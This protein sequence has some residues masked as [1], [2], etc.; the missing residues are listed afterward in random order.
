MFGGLSLLHLPDTRMCKFGW[1]TVPCRRSCHGMRDCS[2]VCLCHR[3]ALQT[4]YA[5]GFG[6]HIGRIPVS[7]KLQSSGRN[8]GDYVPGLVNLDG[9]ADCVGAT[10]KHVKVNGVA[11]LQSLMDRDICGRQPPSAARIGPFILGRSGWQF[12]RLWRFWTCELLASCHIISGCHVASMADL[13]K[14]YV[15]CWTWLAQHNLQLICAC[16]KGRPVDLSLEVAPAA[17]SSSGSILFLWA[18]VPKSMLCTGWESLWPD[19]N[20]R[21]VAAWKLAEGE[22]HLSSLRCICCWYRISGFIAECGSLSWV[23]NRLSRDSLPMRLW[24]KSELMEV[25]RTKTLCRAQ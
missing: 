10:A 19:V 22:L 25:G 8:S 4:S 12:A 7:S 5:H 13:E 16:Q 11:N 3:R 24:R 20:A 18:Q 2:S 17:F 23:D 21:P 9:Y 1:G 6:K 14:L 15:T